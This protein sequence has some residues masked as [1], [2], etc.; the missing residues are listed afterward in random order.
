MP[1]FRRVTMKEFAP[2]THAGS[3][4]GSLESL[5]LSQQLQVPALGSSHFGIIPCQPVNV[6]SGPLQTQ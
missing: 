6:A 3:H 1:V 4:V 2:C 5:I